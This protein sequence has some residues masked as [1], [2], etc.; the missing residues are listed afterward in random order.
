MSLGTCSSVLVRHCA[1]V[2]LLWFSYLMSRLSSMKLHTDSLS[3]NFLTYMFLVFYSVFKRIIFSISK[4]FWRFHSFDKLKNIYNT[5]YLKTRC[6]ELFYS[7]RCRMRANV[8]QFLV[9]WYTP[10]EGEEVD[11]ERKLSRGRH[12]LTSFSL[13]IDTNMVC[14]AQKSITKGLGNL[15]TRYIPIMFILILIC[16]V[17]KTTRPGQGK[18]GGGLTETSLVVPDFSRND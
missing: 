3:H 5:W 16:V 2:E 13:L 10:R 15:N 8:L 17:P 18:G 11:L 9:Q 14:F 1:G 12:G 6:L 7:L 4:L